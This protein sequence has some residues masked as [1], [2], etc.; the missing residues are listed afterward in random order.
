[1]MSSLEE[2][3]NMFRSDDAK[4]FNFDPS[5]EIIHSNNQVFLWPFGF[6]E[7]VEEVHSPL[8]KWNGEGHTVVFILW[9]VVIDVMYLT[10][11]A[12]PYISLVF[13]CIVG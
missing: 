2:M 9:H 1:M 11:M 12:S 3:L 7:W 10:I 8:S 13:S 4:C 5:C 6:R